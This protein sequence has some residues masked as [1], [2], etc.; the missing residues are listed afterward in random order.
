MPRN[1]VDLLL[2]GH[3]QVIR[4][5]Q[6]GKFR[7]RQQEE[8]LRYIILQTYLRSDNDGGYELQI[9]SPHLIMDD[10]KEVILSVLASSV[11]QL[12]AGL[13]I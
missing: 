5:E 4:G 9:T 10:L 1:L 11:P 8:L 7:G 2:T 6:L 12:C 13:G 3:I